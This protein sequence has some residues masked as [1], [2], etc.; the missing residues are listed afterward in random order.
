MFN[1]LFMERRLSRQQ[2]DAI[3]KLVLP[4]ALPQPNMLVYLRNLERVFI[5]FEQDDKAKGWYRVVREEGE[6]PKLVGK[7]HTY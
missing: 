1:F 6:E 5:A 7:R 2:L 4:D 3:T